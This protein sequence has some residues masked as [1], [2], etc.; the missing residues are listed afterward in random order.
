[1][2]WQQ[3]CED[4]SLHNL[5]YKIE[6]NKQGQVVMSPASVRHV[7]FQA[8]IMG[9]L[10]DSLPDGKVVPE[11]PIET[12]E[13]IKVADVAWLT[14]EQSEAVKNNI[15]SAFAAVICVEVLSPGNTSD[16]MMQKKTLYFAGG[17]EEF[18]ICD[19]EGNMSF[20]QKSG[21]IALS[22]LVPDF[23]RLIVI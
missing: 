6:L 13:G 12:R 20:Y 5:P 19:L 14:L 7:F 9:L 4:K 10:R 3:V 18:W 15:S 1:M 23:P 17:A 21:Q 2:D 11:F 22:N 8:E 16:E